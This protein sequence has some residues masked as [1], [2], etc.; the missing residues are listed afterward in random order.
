MCGRYT[1]IR[2]ADFTDMFPWIRP[3]VSTPNLPNSLT[4]GR[5]NIAPTQTVPVVTA[6]GEPRVEFFKWGLVPSWSK[7]GT[8]DAKMINARVEGV[9]EKP[10]FRAAFRK[11]RCL[12]P[13][14]GFYEWKK[15][16][17]GKTKTPKYIRMK[18][19]KPFAF[20][21]L[22]EVWHDR[23]APRD[24][25]PLVTCTIITGQPNEL[26]RDIHD[27]MPVI[28][29]PKH[30][31]QWLETPEEQ[32]ESLLRLLAPYPPDLMEAYTVS[33]EVNSPKNDAPRLIEPAAEEPL[34]KPAPKAVHQPELF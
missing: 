9:A 20:A 3:P 22:W 14:S 18:D 19:G 29:Q 34:A 4:D 2:L 1:L 12:V 24:T 11:R 27:R 7:E 32:A 17:D 6:H 28:L 25:P 8:C 16:P 33:R 21:G 13:A 10:A 30:Y 26:V 31:R 5:F 15:G 23:A